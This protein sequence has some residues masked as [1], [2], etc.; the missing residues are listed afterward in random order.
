[1]LSLD[2]VNQ[3]WQTIESRHANILCHVAQDRAKE[4][5]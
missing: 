5:K 2:A 3:G 1:M 4:E